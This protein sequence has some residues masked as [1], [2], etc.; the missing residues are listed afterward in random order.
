VTLK[1][2]EKARERK[3]LHRE[4]RK[5]AKYGP[6]AA[7]KDMRGR[8]GNHALGERNGRWNSKTRRITKHGY[9]AV[10]VPAS[11]PHAWGPERLKYFKYA[12]EHVLVMMNV[13]G[14]PL[15]PGEVVHHKN[16]DKT[17]NRVE[18]LE[19]LT[20]SAHAVE[21]ADVAERDALGR[22]QPDLPRARQFPEVRHG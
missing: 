12:Y 8:H 22:F 16:G 10:R 6:E 15:Q 14:R 13:Q 21:H 3:R 9:V 5:I 7:G 4:R 20:R 2:R 11:H 1:D 19:L 18:N 17:D